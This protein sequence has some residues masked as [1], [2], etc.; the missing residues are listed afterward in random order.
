MWYLDSGCS[1]HMTGQK[2]MLSNFKE[3]YC[4]SVRFDNDQF[5][6]IMG[7]GDVQHDNVTIKKVSYVEGLRHNRFSIGQFC[8]KSLEVNFKAKTCSVRTEEG[9][10]LLVHQQSGQ[11]KARQRT[12]SAQIGKR[13]SLYN[14]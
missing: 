11:R 6:P 4:G 10:E 1:K 12:S 13:T 8:D 3:K 2:D 7:Y 9:E 14:M 5:S